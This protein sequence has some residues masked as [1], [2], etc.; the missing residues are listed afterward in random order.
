MTRDTRIVICRKCR[1]EFLVPGD[2]AGQALACPHC[3][4]RITVSV[5]APPQ[6]V[7]VEC[8]YCDGR[9]SCRPD[10]VG[11]TINCPACARRFIFP[12]PRSQIE[13]QL[14]LPPTR[15]LTLIPDSDDS[16]GTKRYVTIYGVLFA[17]CGIIGWTITLWTP[18]GKNA[19]VHYVCLFTACAALVTVVS[20]Y[21]RWRWYAIAG[22]VAVTLLI[23][24]WRFTQDTYVETLRST[25]KMTKET[26]GRFNSKCYYR[27]VVRYQ[28]DGSAICFTCEGP[29]S[30]DS[31]KPHG[32]WEYLNW[33]PL[34]S[35]KMWFWYGELVTEGEWHVLN[36]RR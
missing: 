2:L 29:T 10:Q 35:G 18:P 25:D 12:D 4:S 31:G 15:Q 8:P 3:Q 36:K 1:K 16:I 13:T 21:L 6:Q 30:P 14:I 7:I 11:M 23:F 20:A 24:G 5:P 32:E 19:F 22:G 17:I 28:G 34:E 9:V 33:D 27:E 26:I